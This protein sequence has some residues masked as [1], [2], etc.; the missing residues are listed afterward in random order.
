MRTHTHKWWAWNS[1]G[2]V[3]NH[4]ASTRSERAGFRG[5]PGQQAEPL[6]CVHIMI[7]HL[8]RR[9][10]CWSDRWEPTRGQQF[11]CPLFLRC[12]GDLGCP[13]GGSGGPLERV[14]HG[15]R[16]PIEGLENEWPLPES[17]RVK[18]S[19][20][21][22]LLRRHTLRCRSCHSIQGETCS[23]HTATRPTSEMLFVLN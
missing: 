18:H 10:S 6:F 17:P 8:F 15:R 16:R 21:S 3:L 14:K 1:T 22:S 4:H 23:S 20:P 13:W 7:D 12:A 9:G 19:T 5:P 11:R 2:L